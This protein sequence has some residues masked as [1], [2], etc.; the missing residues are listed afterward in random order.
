VFE[1]SLKWTSTGPRHTE[2]A[3]GRSRRTTPGP[4]N[5]LRAATVVRLGVCGCYGAY[6]TGPTLRTKSGGGRWMPNRAAAKVCGQD[7]TYST[8]LMFSTAGGRGG[9]SLPSAT[10]FSGRKE[11]RAHVPFRELPREFGT[12]MLCLSVA[13]WKMCCK[14][15][16]EHSKLF[17][18]KWYWLGSDRR[19]SGCLLHVR[20]CHLLFYRLKDIVVLYISIFLYYSVPIFCKNVVPI[21]C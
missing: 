3:A 6:A 1:F 11:G 9:K 7:V 21:L 15:F 14:F 4:R 2:V 10:T 8:G 13:P 17:A 18:K 20:R 5:S 12:S 19:M 16:Y